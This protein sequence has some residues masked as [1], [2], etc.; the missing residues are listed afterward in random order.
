[1]ANTEDAI[2]Y[3]NVVDGKVSQATGFTAAF[4]S[5]TNKSRTLKPNEQVY[6]TD[7]LVRRDVVLVELVTVDTTTLADGQG[8]RYRAEV[9]LKL[10]GSRRKSCAW[11]HHTPEPR[12]SLFVPPLPASA[13]R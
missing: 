2:V 12:L 9:S 10:P 4:G 6:V 3:T 11:T 1:M 8:T 5:N 13:L 7:I